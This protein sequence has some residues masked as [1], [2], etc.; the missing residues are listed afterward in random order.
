[1]T[2]KITTEARTTFQDIAPNPPANKWRLHQYSYSSW[3]IYCGDKLI[4]GNLL[5]DEARPLVHEHNAETDAAAVKVLP[6][7]PRRHAT[8]SCCGPGNAPPFSV[9]TV[10]PRITAPASRN[11]RAIAEFR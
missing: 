7:S 8:G 6:S 4:T 5:E 3:D 11:A 9:V 2:T 1:M 10:L